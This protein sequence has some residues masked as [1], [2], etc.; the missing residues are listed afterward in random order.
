MSTHLDGSA[1]PLPDLTDPVA[2]PFWAGTREG[3]L[4]VPKCADCGYRFWPPEPVCPECLG[5]DLDWVD[6]E[7]S[8]TLW[9]YAV[10][11]RAL[12][13]AFADVLPYTVGLIEL[14]DTIKMY[15]IVPGDGSDL[16]VGVP[17]T[18]VFEKATEEVTFVRWRPS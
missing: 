10:Y 1:R 17:M 18:A 7:P 9:S 16:S 4:T 12:D 8:G 2:A 6:I 13:P 14:T 3:R 5:L 15:G 11:H